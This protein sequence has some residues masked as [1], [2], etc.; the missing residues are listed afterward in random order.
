MR[1]KWYLPSSVFILAQSCVPSNCVASRLLSWHDCPPVR[2][3]RWTLHQRW[4]QR[5]VQRPCVVRSTLFVLACTGDTRHFLESLDFC[6]CHGPG[7]LGDLAFGGPYLAHCFFYC[8]GCH[9]LHSV[10]F[11]LFGSPYLAHHSFFTFWG[12]ISC[13]CFFYFDLFG[14]IFW[15]F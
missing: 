2:T 11:L 13:I 1:T 12:P 9:I 7:Y 3:W 4:I 6:V 15:S 10:V 8:L 5:L 14:C